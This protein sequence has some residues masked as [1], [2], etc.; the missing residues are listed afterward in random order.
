MLPL[1][2]NIPLNAGQKEEEDLSADRHMRCGGRWSTTCAR[3][4]Y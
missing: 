3:L 4:Q 1:S 2:G